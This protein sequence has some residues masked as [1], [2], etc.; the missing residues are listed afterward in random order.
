MEGTK[1]LKVKWNLCSPYKSCHKVEM[2]LMAKAL[3]S[4]VISRNPKLEVQKFKSKLNL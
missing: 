3:G 4:K 2:L 1:N